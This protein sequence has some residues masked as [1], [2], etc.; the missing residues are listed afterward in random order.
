MYLPDRRWFRLRFLLLAV[1][2]GLVGLVAVAA[3]AG[4]EKQPSLGEPRILV[5]ALDGSG[6]YRSIQEA[7]DHAGSG[8]TI[9]IRAGEYQ[10]DVTV[11]GKERVRLVGEGVDR[12][13]ILGRRRVGAF[14]VG[15]WPYGATEVELSG[16]TINSHGGLAIGI[17]NG[18]SMLLRDVKINGLLF[19]QQV[20]DL[21]IER[22]EI[23][24]SETTGVSFA[25]SE[26][27]LVGNY[28][29]DNDHGVTVAGKSHVRLE[30]NVITR[31]LFEGV[32]VNDLARVVLISNTIVKN[33]GGVAFLGN[34]EGEAS[35]N[36]VGF[37]KIGFL[38]GASAHPRLTYNA[39]YNSEHDYVRPGS[40][41]VPAPELRPEMDL[42]VDPHFVDLG[43]DDFRLHP[44]SP[45]LRVG[46]FPYLGALPPVDGAPH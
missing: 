37:N 4:G 23:G 43:H 30:R 18:R 6:D 5:V 19:G 25:D 17:F 22:C 9:Q 41:N 35:G 21:R 44:K 26:A 7:V 14:H 2:A 34:A 28:I 10:E 16:L 39:V 12:V 3:Q 15:K 27:V 42:T 8:D 33:G 20:R 36:I 24:G 13:K 38:I 40:P 31:N 1:V 29:H 46:S 11:H 45:L 32:V